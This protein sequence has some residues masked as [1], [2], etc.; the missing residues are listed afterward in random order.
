M[1]NTLRYG[2]FTELDLTAFINHQAVRRLTCPLV[3]VLLLLTPTFP[4][5]DGHCLPPPVVAVACRLVSLW[6]GILA[7][8]SPWWGKAVS[9][10]QPQNQLDI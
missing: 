3:G 2:Y 7:C 4:L 10:A 8:P 9:P 1:R 5:L 6:T